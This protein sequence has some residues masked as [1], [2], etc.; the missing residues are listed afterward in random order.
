[1]TPRRL[2]KPL[3]ADPRVR[4]LITSRLASRRIS[5]RNL[6]AAGGAAGLLGTLAACGTQGTGTGGGSNGGGNGDSDELFWANWSL[7]LDY[8]ADTGSYPTLDRFQEETGINVTYAEDIDGNESYYGTIQGQLAQGQNFGQDLICFT[9]FM[10]ARLIQ[11]D[12]TQ[13]LDHGNIPNLGNLL[14]S[15]QEVE[16]DPGRN[17]TVTWQSGL[18]GIAWNTD[19]VPQGVHSVEDLLT[20]PELHGRV[21]VLGEMRDTVGLIMMDQGVD[22]TSFDD[23]DFENAL[24]KLSAALSSGQIRQVESSYMEHLV[25][26]D[27][28]ACMAWSG[29]I[30]QLNFEEGDRWDFAIPEAGGNLWSDNLLIPSGAENKA[31]AEALMNFYLDPEVAAEVAAYV[32]YVCPVEGAQEAMEQIDPELA[33]D[34]LIFPTDETLSNV[35]VIRSMDVE[36]ENELQ[37]RFQSVIGN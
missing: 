2:H 24:D 20:D 1:M 16:F 27:A 23:D 34:P 10:A 5:R 22:I 32:N 8:D 26:G 36:E 14:P 17:H 21:L 18:T 29:D 33:E 37:S 4:R 35:Q 25:S 13:E 15:L 7:Y 3:P 30:T 11:D 19:A 31:N 6:L 12:Q 9:D 28:L